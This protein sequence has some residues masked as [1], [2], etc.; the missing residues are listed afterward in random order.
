MSMG[1]FGHGHG[2]TAVPHVL[3][4]LIP[5]LSPAQVV[6]LLVIMRQT[7]GWH[8]THDAISISQLVRG[9]GLARSTVIQAIHDLEGQGLVVVLRVATA[10]GDSAPS[11]F[12]L[13]PVFT[14][15]QEVRPAARGSVKPARGWSEIR[16]HKTNPEIYSDHPSSASAT[17]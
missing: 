6:V 10:A 5:S 17:R 9:T 1:S 15:A 8:K 3:F 16:T 11:V 13:G 2:F 4:S 7:I 12:R 14:A